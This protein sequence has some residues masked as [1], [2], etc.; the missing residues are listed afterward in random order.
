MALALNFI[1]NGS[2]FPSNFWVLN[3]VASPN[4][5][6]KLS[7]VTSGNGLFLA[8]GSNN[9][10][11]TSSDGV[12]WTSNGPVFS[13]NTAEGS[14]LAFNNG[15]FAAVA[16]APE[17]AWA[18]ASSLSWN[19]AALPHPSFVESFRGVTSF[20][21]NSFAACG[22]LGDIRT[23]TDGGVSWQ[24]NRG[25]VTFPDLTG[26]AAADD[27][28]TL[29]SVGVRSNGLATAIFS[30]NGGTN[31]TAATGTTSNNLNAVAFSGTTGGFV[32][33]GSNGVVL[34]S[35][36]SG[37]TWTP[38]TNITSSNLYGITFARSNLLRSV[39]VIVGQGGTVILVGTA[40]PAPTSIVNATNCAGVTN[41]VFAFPLPD[42]DHP[43]GTLTIDWYANAV[44]FSGETSIAMNTNSIFPSYDPAIL[45]GAN[46][47]TYFTNF[48][49]ARDLRTGFVSTNRT[50]V[51][52]K[53]NPRP[54]STLVSFNTTECNEGQSNTLTTVLTGLGPW[55]VVW[56]SNGV[57]VTQVVNQAIAGP[58]I[59]TFIV[60][61]TNTFLNSAFTNVYF[62]SSISNDDTTCIGNLPKD[63][64]GVDMVLV[65]PR[66]TSTLGSFN[67]VTCNDGQSLTLTNVLTGLGPWTVVWSS[68]NVL[69]TQPVDASVPGPFTNTFT[70]VPTST[71]ANAPFVNSFFVQ[72]VSNNGTMCIGDQSSDITGSVDVTVN[73]RPTSTL[74][75]FSTTSCNEGPAFT[76]TNVLTGLG[77]WTVVWSSNGVPV[78]QPVN[79]IAPGPYTNNFS[80]APTNT[81]LN[82]AYTN[83]YFV[84]S[85]SNNGTMCTGNQAGDLTGQV[86]VTI[87]PRPTSTLSSLVTTN[88][89]DG[90]PVTLTNVL[91]G[92][93]PWTVVWSSNNVLVTQPVNVA[94]AGPYTN[95]FTVVP[96]NTAPN[97]S[98]TNVYFVQSVSNNGTLCIGDQTADLTGQVRI[99]INPLPPAPVSLGNVTNC[100]GISNPPLSVTVTNGAT[101]D[102]FDANTNL[103]F[104]GT[105]NYFPTNTA[106]GVYTN[107][108]QTRLNNLGCT[109]ANFTQVV[110]VIENCT[111]VISGITLN[112]GTNAV[113]QWYGD[114]VL[115]SAT[116]LT[117][118]VDW[119]NLTQGVGGMT[120]YWTNST[121]PPPADNFFRL[122]APTN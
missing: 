106:V 87:N 116:N 67:T 57:P 69:V 91:T 3:P 77:P 113:I 104:S 63:I 81:F 26:I 59:D 86:T 75:S 18:D 102:W 54:T 92:L 122:Y 100:F 93:G 2:P 56:S 7:A 111:N 99:V 4:P 64:T 84:L 33:V 115:Q 66:P 51:I 78:T 118:P 13:Q 49:Q 32:A 62:V 89:D 112:N 1:T 103:L 21:T 117:P 40:P 97:L 53:V 46:A 28:Q 43:A 9:I 39:G 76:L 80:V 83:I 110:F 94:A 15:H 85:V 73:P 107:Y 38:Q 48:A 8:T 41:A 47:A 74:T 82:S 101:A 16:Q 105:T 79:V 37:V 55:T 109:S 10:V 17:I 72:S 90:L 14:G 71:L 34:V 61:P 19:G 11:F 35:T 24:T 27:G 98:Y 96:T 23:S 120:N 5:N 30:T 108:A 52:L 6:L 44:P 58:Y 70:V 20:G 50:P 31:W 68:N 22:I 29:V 42:S 95:R 60:V 114:F 65:N 88:C 119:T 25:R 36:D 121:V 45:D 12:N